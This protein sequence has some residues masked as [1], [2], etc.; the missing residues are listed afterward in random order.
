VAMRRFAVGGVDLIGGHWHPVFE[1][2][3]PCYGGQHINCIKTARDVGP[4]CRSMEH[5]VEVLMATKSE[6]SKDG[7][8]DSGY[9][10]S[11]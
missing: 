6:I 10:G 1:I 8:Q 2:H 4:Q 7:W 3:E 9:G 5:A 11:S